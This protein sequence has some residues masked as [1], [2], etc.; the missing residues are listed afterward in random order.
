MFIATV[1]LILSLTKSAFF[2]VLCIF[3][4]RELLVLFGYCN[5]HS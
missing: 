1:K 3:K 4:N 2:V 5:T